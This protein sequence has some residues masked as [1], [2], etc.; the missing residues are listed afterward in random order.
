MSSSPK[1]ANSRPP[2]HLSR[3]N[4]RPRPL[5]ATT[6]PRQSRRRS[7]SR[8]TDR[9]V[10]DVRKLLKANRFA[11]SVTQQF[12]YLPPTPGADEFCTS[13][14]L[15]LLEGRRELG[16]LVHLE[17]GTSRPAAGGRRPRSQVAWGW[18]AQPPQ[19]R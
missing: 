11:W 7:R 14:V 12:W 9:Q 18:A 10:L 19:L 13:H 16:R 17:T 3:S 2:S 8:G 1:K 4:R 5:P 6:L 15:G